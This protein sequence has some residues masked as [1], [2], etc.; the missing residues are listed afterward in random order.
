ML[1]K[2]I[3]DESGNIESAMVLIPLIFLFLCSIQLVSAIYI[4][5]SDQSDVQSQA[6]TR[7]I[8]GTFN[9][10]D[11]IVNIPS[12]YPFEDQKILIVTKRREIPLL[13][14]GLIQA[15]GR[16]LQSEVTGVAV[17]ENRP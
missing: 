12:R 1:R 9:R 6:S 2:F 5:N 3:R 7:A 15:L 17:I 11:S 10:T 4:R 14:P 8:S 13:V 16:Q